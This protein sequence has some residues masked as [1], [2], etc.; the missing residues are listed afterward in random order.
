VVLCA[1]A[2]PSLRLLALVS[3]SVKRASELLIFFFLI[4]KRAETVLLFFSEK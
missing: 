1:C 4:E 3:K 2:T